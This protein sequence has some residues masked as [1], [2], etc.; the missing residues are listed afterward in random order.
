MKDLVFFTVLVFFVLSFPWFKLIP[1]KKREVSPEVQ[2]IITF[3][4]SSPVTVATMWSLFVALRL[5]AVVL[6][7]RNTARNNGNRH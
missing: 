6:Q 7:L 1:V 4:A 3:V 2:L 5:K